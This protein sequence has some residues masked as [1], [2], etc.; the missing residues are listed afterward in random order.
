MLRKAYKMYDK[1][2]KEIKKVHKKYQMRESA[3]T[4]AFTGMGTG[5]GEIEQAN[6][7]LEALDLSNPSTPDHVSKP[8]ANQNNDDI[9]NK[10]TNN[11]G[12]NNGGLDNDSLKEDADNYQINID[13]KDGTLSR[14]ATDRLY[15]AVNFGYGTFQLA[16]SLIPPKILKIIEFLGFEGDRETGLESLD[17]ASRSRDMKAPLAR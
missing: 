9:N 14:E 5:G 3:S 10:Q 12:G 1:L 8:L 2:Y 7:A 6:E 4:N 11:G 17:I 13:L 16:I 15:G